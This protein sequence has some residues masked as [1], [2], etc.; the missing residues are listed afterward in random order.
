MDPRF[1]LREICK[2]C[3]LL[4]DHLSH[5]EKRC[6]DCCIKHFLTIEALAEEAITLDKDKSLQTKIETLP[7]TIRRLQNQWFEDPDKN[8][9]HVSQE[10][11]AIRK[12]Y[13]IDNFDVVFK[14][15]CNSC[16]DGVCRVRRGDGN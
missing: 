11:R 16:S 6:T 8:A 12:E 4:E 3:I 9:H 13:Q 10:L 5:N 14:E 7:G 15:S 2:Q 1:N